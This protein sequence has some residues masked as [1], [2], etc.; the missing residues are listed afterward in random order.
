MLRITPRAFL[1]YLSAG[2][3]PSF[4]PRELRAFRDRQIS[5]VSDGESLQ[6]DI[7]VL[8]IRVKIKR[9]AR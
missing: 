4:F 9:D 3:A 1:A 2:F 6:V 5:L 7:T 8:L